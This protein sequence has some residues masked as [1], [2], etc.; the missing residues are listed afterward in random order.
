VAIPS[1]YVAGTDGYY[2]TSTD[3]INWTTR[4]SGVLQWMSLSWSLSVSSIAFG[5]GI[6]VIVG[7]SS[8]N[9]LTYCTTSSD[10]INWGSP[11][12]IDNNLW[13]KPRV[14]FG[15]GYFWYFNEG[16]NKWGTTIDGTTWVTHGWGNTGMTGG[17]YCPG[18]TSLVP[19]VMI[20]GRNSG[21]FKYF[22][23]SSGTWYN[24]PIQDNGF[25]MGDY[26]GVTYD[27]YNGCFIA[28][29]RNTGLFPAEI[30]NS[31]LDATIWTGLYGYPVKA[32]DWT[33]I[34]YGGNGVTIMGGAYVSGVTVPILSRSTDGGVHWT[35]MFNSTQHGD[36]NS[37]INANG[38]FVAL[39]S[40]NEVLYAVN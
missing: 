17:V 35:T 40:T 10:G 33:S 29:A 36:V 11:V 5:N 34:A 12:F 26:S 6:F 16:G 7:S 13:V 31:N 3:V 20:C 30:V 21:Q 25:L 39:T 8:V 14:I 19:G 9:G 4:Y 2:M 24:A 32:G 22:W 15:G 18:N 28:V 23:N 27:D 37:I 38:F 1:G